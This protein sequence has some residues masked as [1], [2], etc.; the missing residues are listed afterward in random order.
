MP[1]GCE[2]RPGWPGA[3]SYL[4]SH[5]PGSRLPVGLA[6]L[7]KRAKGGETP[8]PRHSFIPALTPAPAAR[9]TPL[10]GPRGPPAGS[11]RRPGPGRSEARLP[12]THGRGRRPS[13]AAPA[14]AAALPA[15]AAA[16]V[17]L[18]P[19]L[20]PRCQRGWADCTQGKP[21]RWGRSAP[22]SAH[23]EGRLW[24]RLGWLAHRHRG[25]IAQP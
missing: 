21:T 2:A 10:W 23:A 3:G 22:S 8:S 16:R 18:V 24:C 9:G 4:G 19:T 6:E 7:P 11:G 14:P 12:R 1:F 20:R 5:A 13:G 25:A 15:P 17:I